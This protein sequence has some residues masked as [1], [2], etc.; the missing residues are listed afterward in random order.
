MTILL[1][2]LFFLL[3]G[4]V[5]IGLIRK[6][7]ARLEGRSGAPVIQPF[8]RFGQLWKKETIEPTGASAIFR[9]APYVL[10]G[11]SLTIAAVG[12]FIA[13]S[14]GLGSSSDLFVVVGLL[15][16]GN[17]TMALAGLD[18]GTSFGGMGASRELTVSSLVE[19]TL[20]IAIFALSIPAGTS[21]L[22]AICRTAL[23]DPG[24]L[25]TP[26]DLLA[27][28]AF[29]VV[30]IAEA[31]RLPIDNPTTHLELT[32][33]HEAMLLEYSGPRLAVIEWASDIRLALLL[34]LIANLF[35]PLGIANHQANVAMFV[36]SITVLVVKVLLLATLIALAE[37]AIT[38]IR[39]TRV[40]ELLSGSFI[41][42]FLSIMISF[43]V[44][45][46]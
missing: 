16:L 10:L 14:D 6:V 9:F 29:V 7:H 21:S 1:Q 15:F 30:V 46:R 36:I 37:T 34:G 35:F 32:M 19:P 8:R 20:L 43:F 26:A 3:I 25:L 38:K 40:P 22:D 13:T 31:K 2:L 24:R 5:S 44:S 17:I 42:A 33:I 12:P 4:P 11:T 28:G 27:L 39:L 18:L 41:F 45:R 23:S